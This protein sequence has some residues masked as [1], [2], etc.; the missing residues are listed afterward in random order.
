LKSPGAFETAG[1]LVASADVVIENFRP[2]TM[3]RLG[4]GAE[5]MTRS[6]HA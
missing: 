5:A 2:G 6:T 3:D 1:K 4:L